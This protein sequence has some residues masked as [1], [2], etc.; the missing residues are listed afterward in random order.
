MKISATALLQPATIKNLPVK[1]GSVGLPKPTGLAVPVNGLSSNAQVNVAQ[2]QS[3]QGVTDWVAARPHHEMSAT[4]GMVNAEATSVPMTLQ[5]KKGGSYAFSG[6]YSYSFTGKTTPA[7][8]ITVRDAQ[9]KVVSTTKGNALNYVATS[10]GQFTV[11]LSITPA[12]GFS[13]K[14]TRHQLNAFQ[15]LSKIPVS[16]GNK[17]LDA[18]LAGG[19]NWWHDAGVVATPSTTVIAP[20]VKQ[21]AGART[22]IYY[23]YLS[24]S[25]SY[26]SA[27]DKKGFVATDRAQK[28]AIVS[29]FNYLSSLVNVTF[30]QN[31][32][33][34]DI[35]FGNNDQTSSAGYANYPS[36]NP[37]RPSILM[38]DNSNNPE[39]AGTKLAEQGGYGWY[40]LVHELGHAMGLK[41]PGAYNAG[42]GSTPGPYLPKALDNRSTSVMSYN[43]PTASTIVTL[44][45]TAT[46]TSY[47]LRTST[48]ASIPSTYQALDIA[49]LQYLYG[50]NTNTQTDTLAVN[51]AH[52]KF[53]TVW[54]PKGVE[55]NAAETT[56]SN[57]F[58]LRGGGYSSIS[59]RTE[60]SNLANFK[61]QLK[62]QGFNDAKANVAASSVMSSLK[63]KKADATLYNGKNT[64][65]LSHGSQFTKVVG[66]TAADKFF[67]STYSTDI[68]GGEGD[69]VDTLYLQ[70]TAKD[71]VIDRADGRATAKTGGAVIKFSSI[72][73]IAFYK[74][75]DALTHA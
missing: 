8:S 19:S 53:E 38:L 54:A 33:L 27:A 73:A 12:K 23:D 25:E 18:V 31:A 46:D 61:S 59:V 14:F 56:R 66:G 11:T 48:A 20:N 16:S 22:T 67:A 24:G 10:D 75:T 4:T 49:A 63:A 35:K 7:V 43:N 69:A 9:G 28:D 2:T 70:G 57:L 55:L 50:A 32:Q 5:L 60:T 68:N 30:E 45:G 15:T 17:N 44:T 41:H 13:A 58:D 74:S 64:L 1:T 26:L 39:N 34:A 3:V 37:S 51:D 52:S 42:G 6:A 21:I 47:T 71:W 62:S 72:E 65:A 36:T 40:T 29:A